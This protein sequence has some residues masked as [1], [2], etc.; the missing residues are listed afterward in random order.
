METLNRIISTAIPLP[1]ND[2]DTDQIIP[3][4]FLK[5]SNKTSYSDCLFAD[6]R[7]YNGKHKKDFWLNRE[8]SGKILVTQS[9]FGCGS[10]REHAAWAIKDFGISVV[11]AISFADIFKNN[12]LNNGI[13][14]II[15]NQSQIDLTIQQVIKNPKFEIK[16][17]LETQTVEIPGICTTFFEINAF[18]KECILK[19]LDEIDYLVNL[20]PDIEKFE[21]SINN[22]L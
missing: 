11:I 13:I 9:N 21:K 19:G 10:S 8:F 12:A 4:R 2:V 14:P 6:W 7:N 22:K 20:K 16:V 1:I 15:L 3:A 18:K 5:E 17:D